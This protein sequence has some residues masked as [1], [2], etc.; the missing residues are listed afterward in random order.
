VHV[1]VYDALGRVVA[2][3]RVQQGAGERKEEFDLSACRPGVLLF[4]LQ[5]PRGV[6]TRRIVR[7]SR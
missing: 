5:T 4:K 7:S 1:T 2:S 6:I 3:R